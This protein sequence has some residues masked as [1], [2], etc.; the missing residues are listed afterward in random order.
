M[1][2]SVLTAAA[3]AATVASAVVVALLQD[4]TAAA[5]TSTLQLGSKDSS[6][7]LDGEITSN[8]AAAIA[9]STSAQ[10]NHATG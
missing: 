3:A 8:C 9:A 5:A 6:L 4:S 10:A 1:R 7:I 2:G